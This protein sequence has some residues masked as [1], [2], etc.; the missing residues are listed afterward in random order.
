[1][2][3]GRLSY[4]PYLSDE[5]FLQ[6]LQSRFPSAP[7]KILM[8]AWSAAS[9]VFPWTTRL[10]WGD[11]DLKW[12]PEACISIPSYKGFYTVK[13]FMEVEPMAGSNIQN[14]LD[15]AQNYKFNKTSE[16]MSPLAVADSI[17]KY[18]RL[19]MI[20]LHQMVP[21]DPGSPGRICPDPGRYRSIR[22]YRLLLQREDP[23][24]MFPRFI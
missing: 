19:A 3:W 4:N 5:L 21:G 7:G 12:F 23:R 15:W 16:L 17:S 1:M 22:N 13:D 24:C 8:N 9:M 10:V 20:Y 6:K 18:S 2:L 11:I 14:I